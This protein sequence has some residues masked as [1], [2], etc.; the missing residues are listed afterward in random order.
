MCHGCDVPRHVSRPYGQMDKALAY[1]A[2]DSGFNPQ[3][4]LISLSFYIFWHVFVCFCMFV[5]VSCRP[6][7]LQAHSSSSVYLCGGVQALNEASDGRWRRR[8]WWVRKNVRGTAGLKRRPARGG[9]GR[10]GLGC[11]HV[12]VHD[13]LRSQRLYRYVVAGF[14]L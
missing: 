1:G 5:C 10:D 12:D 8:R 2:R 3:Y 13:V 14:C 6:V 7:C 11:V 9:G 4:G